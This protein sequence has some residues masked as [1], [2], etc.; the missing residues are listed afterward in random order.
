[1]PDIVNW[2]VEN[3]QLIDSPWRR[4]PGCESSLHSIWSAEGRQT[5]SWTRPLELYLPGLFTWLCV[6]PDEGD[7][8]DKGVYKVKFG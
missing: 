5:T 6:Q 2:G 8:Q 4:V 7:T 3:V 1:M